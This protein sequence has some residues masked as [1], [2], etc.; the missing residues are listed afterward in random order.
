MDSQSV[1][2]LTADESG[3]HVLVRMAAAFLDQP[4]LRL[5]LTQAQR[6]WNLDGSTCHRHLRELID[7]EFL[8]IRNSQYRLR[9]DP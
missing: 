7:A 1:S 2:H 9:V 6:L 5:T 8:E 3:R 4:G